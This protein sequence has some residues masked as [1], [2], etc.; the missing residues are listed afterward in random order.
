MIK[1]ILICIVLLVTV[2]KNLSKTLSKDLLNNNESS[3]DYIRLY[4]NAVINYNFN[5]LLWRKEAMKA[6]CLGPTKVVMW[7]CDSS[8]CNST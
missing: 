5:I 1:L 2:S 7:P 8:G 4:N 6:K 3:L